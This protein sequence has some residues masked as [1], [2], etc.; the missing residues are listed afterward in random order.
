MN[1]SGAVSAGHSSLAAVESIK[2]EE[3]IKVTQ[4]VQ[5]MGLAGIK[6]NNTVDGLCLSPETRHA[7]GM[8]ID[9]N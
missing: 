3:K 2:E 7:W 9:C 8:L 6:I 5:Y 4:M 1:I